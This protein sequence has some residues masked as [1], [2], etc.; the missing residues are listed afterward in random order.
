MVD[1]WIIKCKSYRQSLNCNALQNDDQKQRKV[2]VKKICMRCGEER[3]AEKDFSWKYMNRG[4]RQTRCKYCQSQISKHHYKNNKQLYLD[5]ARAREIQVIEKSQRN[6]IEYLA[7]HPCIDCNQIDARVLEFDH[8]Q[9]EKLGN[10]SRMIGLG[11]SWPTIQAEI[12]KCE[13]RCANCHRIKTHDRGKY[14]RNSNQ[15][16]ETLDEFNEKRIRSRITSMRTNSEN[17]KNLYHYLIEHPCVNCGNTNIICLEFDHVRGQKV[18]S[19]SRLLS[20]CAS[21]RT[22]ETELSKCEVRCAN[23]HRIKT[24]ERGGF[25]RTLVD[26]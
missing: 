16:A 11:Y 1:V 15:N 14:W 10:I 20:N 19:I 24:G 12:A 23:C 2:L 3:D 25:W 26:S 5:R 17:R 4:I 6:L 22:V 7:S 18:N 8:V 13:V 21:W 9:G